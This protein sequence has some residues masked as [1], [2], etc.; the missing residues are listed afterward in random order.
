[1]LNQEGGGLFQPEVFED[2]IFSPDGLRRVDGLKEYPGEGTTGTTDDWVGQVHN[3]GEIWSATLW[4]AYLAA[5]GNSSSSATRATTR[6]EFL[7]TLILHHF[8]LNTDA[9]MPEAAEALLDQNAEDEQTQGRQVIALLDSFHDR[10]ILRVADNVDLWIKNKTGHTG[11]ETVSS[12]FW[13]SPDVWI[14]NNDDNGVTH[15]APEFGQDNWFYARVRNRGTQSCRVFAVTFEVKIWQG[16]Q[17]VYPNDFIPATAT[18][19]GFNLPAGGEQIVKARWPAS[20]VPSAGSHGCLLVSAYSP[21]D[22]ALTGRYVWEDNNLA[23]K[24]LTIVDLQPDDSAE[25]S[26]KLGNVLLRKPKLFRIEIL[27][28]AGLE[29][30]EVAVVHPNRAVAAHLNRSIERSTIKPVSRP[31]W[32]S[33]GRPGR[34]TTQPTSTVNPRPVLT[35]I[36]NARFRIGTLGN[37]D[38]DNE[39]LEINLAPGSE[40]FPDQPGEPKANGVGEEQLDP[41]FADADVVIEDN[42]RGHSIIRFQ[43]GRLVG[44][45]FELSPRYNVPMKLRVKAPAKSR[46]GDSYEVHLV[47]RDRRGQVVGGIT[48]QINIV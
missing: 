18:A 43:P 8:K 6:K 21:T 5:G 15:Q 1:M 34:V 31:G 16:T 10:N 35:A 46:R 33:I 27:R 36:E 23:Q 11:A 41:N 17:F 4:S 24:N 42:D 13:N 40:I 32:A 37:I 2:W 9:T 20:E 7:R 25:I 45:P 38:V 30:L 47:Q 19:V 29:G 39:G 26:F 12:P 28:P 44:F 22:E 3:D 14:R 48:V